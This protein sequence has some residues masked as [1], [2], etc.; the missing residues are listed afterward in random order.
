MIDKQTTCNKYAHETQLK[1]LISDLS[2]W[3]GTD[4][5]VYEMHV[6]QVTVIKSWPN[7][8]DEELC[9]NPYKLTTVHIINLSEQQCQQEMKDPNRL[10]LK[11]CKHDSLLLLYRF[12]T[13]VYSIVIPSHFVQIKTL[14]VNQYLIAETLFSWLI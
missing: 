9:L 3:V 1:I 13:S 10:T 11:H 7:T 4:S 5:N 14:C 6:K 12:C 8:G 2:E